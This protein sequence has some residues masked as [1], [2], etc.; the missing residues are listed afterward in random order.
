MFFEEDIFCLLDEDGSFDDVIKS[1]KLL[2][3]DIN[4]YNRIKYLL[5]DGEVEEVKQGVDQKASSSIEKILAWIRA[6]LE[7]IVEFAKKLFSNNRF[8]S[9]KKYINENMKVPTVQVPKSLGTL[10][11]QINELQAT[12]RN[13]NAGNYVKSINIKIPEPTETMNVNKTQLLH[14]VDTVE[15]GKSIFPSITAAFN[16]ARTKLTQQPENGTQVMG[17]LKDV[18]ENVKSI[19]KDS[20]SIINSIVTNLQ[21]KNTAN[22]VNNEVNGSNKTTKTNNKSTTKAN[23]SEQYIF[24][25]VFDYMVV[26][27]N[28]N[29]LVSESK[30]EFYLMSDNHYVYTICEGLKINELQKESF[31]NLKNSKRKLNNLQESFEYFSDVEIK[32]ILFKENGN[33]C[34]MCNEDGKKVIINLDKDL[35]IL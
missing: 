6:K 16:K 3:E 35:N 19:F 27:T 11:D 5:E 29:V 17:A 31:I 12:L 25:N 18:V 2:E 20:A 33:I 22:Q 9:I 21:A 15:R 4:Y 32:Y 30:E 34:L 7:M 8:E 26:D 14:I 1:I 13:I 24:D 23:K 10:Q 28:R